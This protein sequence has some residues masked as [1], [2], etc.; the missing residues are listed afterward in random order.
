MIIAFILLRFTE[1]WILRLMIGLRPDWS[2]DMMIEWKGRNRRWS[3]V[4]TPEHHI[5]VRPGTAPRTSHGRVAFIVASQT[6]G[7]LTL[8][9]FLATVLDAMVATAGLTRESLEARSLLKAVA[10][11][12]ILHPP[13]LSTWSILLIRDQSLSS[14]WRH[15]MASGI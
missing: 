14:I 5:D 3:V 11:I 10:C 15:D 7:T 12:N 8:V 4:S 6:P 1:L 13:L 2:E 9:Q